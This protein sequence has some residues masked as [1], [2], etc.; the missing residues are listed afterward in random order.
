MMKQQIIAC[1]DGSNSTPA[2]CQW[3][4]W[5][6]TQLQA[7]LTLLHVLT[8]PTTVTTADWS[9]SI[10]LG[11]QEALLAQLVEL[12]LQRELA[13][14]R[15]L[16]RDERPPAEPDKPEVRTYKQIYVRNNQPVG[17]WSDSVRVTLQP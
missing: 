5:A 2:V 14:V 1:V 15:E 10:G 12:D 9:G 11:S 8:Q 17:L 4:A 16:P 3:A 7:P 13:R 6:A